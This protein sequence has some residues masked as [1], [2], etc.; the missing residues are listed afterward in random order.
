MHL[1]TFSPSPVQVA[2]NIFNELCEC[3]LEALKQHT[4]QELD[5][6]AAGKLYT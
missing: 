3:I 1:T 5:S 6:G 2:V 4:W